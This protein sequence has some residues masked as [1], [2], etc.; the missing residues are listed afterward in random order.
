M[1]TLGID[2]GGTK[3]AVAAV[4]D[5]V[6]LSR[7]RV[8]TPQ[9]GMSAVLDAMAEAARAVLAQHPEISRV[10]IGSPGP[11]DFKRG[12]VLFAPNI[13]GMVEAPMVSG[14]QERLG[15]TVVLENDAN[16]AGYAEHRYGA[17]RELHSSI[18]VTL[19]TGIGGGLFIGDKVIRGAHGIAGE[20][21]HMILQDRG[22]QGG[23]G[24]HGTWEA[25]AAGRSIARE[26][27]YS[28][29]RAMTT[30]EVFAQAR[31]GE[32]K[33]LKIIDNAA[34]YTGIGLANLHKIFNPDA[35]VLG[36]G[37]TQVG[38]FYLERVRAA[39]AAFCANYPPLE[40]RLAALG[41]DAGVIGAAAVA[42]P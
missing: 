7:H 19:S 32:A 24:H 27:S 30:E 12:M 11:I 14:L 37:L 29:G 15:L 23:D 33:A 42:I 9:T 6:I 36:G 1:K 35:F 34:H 38:N 17:A 41:T 8:A 16:A 39:A 18:F 10:G 4:E 2:L 25:I 20:I 26:A 28:F 21:G 13:P 40:L 3:I 31:A 22:P 5:G